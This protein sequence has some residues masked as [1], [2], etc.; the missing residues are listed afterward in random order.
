MRN[1]IN[2]FSIAIFLSAFFCINPSHAAREL[3]S[4]QFISSDSTCSQRAS[5]CWQ[6]RVTCPSL[7]SIDARLRIRNSTI[8]AKGAVIFA[9]GGSGKAFWGNQSTAASFALID[10]NNSGFN[11]I[12][13]SWDSAWWS[14]PSASLSGAFDGYPTVACRPATVAKYIR[15]TFNATDSGLAFCASGNSGGSTQVGFML[16]HYGLDSILDLAVPT[17]GPPVSRV[18]I[19]CFQTPGYESM[20]YTD[21]TASTIDQVFRTAKQGP[22]LTKNLTYEELYRNASVSVGGNYLYPSTYVHFVFG[23]NDTTSAVGQGR[24]HFDTLLQ[25]ATPMLGQEFIAG[26]GHQVHRSEAGAGAIRD[27]II[28]ECRKH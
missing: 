12:E 7:S 26:T 6:V 1:R 8:T 23:A 17:S 10:L 28:A 9:E 13:I 11:T 16:S 15:D 3:G 24:F 27:K 18:D 20:W 2:V 4:V 5:D 14:D 22:C 21:D 19:G 25:A